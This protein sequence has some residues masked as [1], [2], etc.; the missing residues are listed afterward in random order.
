MTD[1][2]ADPLLQAVTEVRGHKV[3]APCVL[4]ERIGEGGMGVVY[5]GL[6]LNLGIEVAV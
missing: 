6:H 5:R 2:L 3:L 4:L 1:C